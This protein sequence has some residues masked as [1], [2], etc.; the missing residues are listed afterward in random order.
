M[1]KIYN[2][3]F[4]LLAFIVLF[5]VVLGCNFSSNSSGRTNGKTE[6]TGKPSNNSEVK[7][8]SGENETTGKSGLA[9]DIIGTWEGS[10][11]GKQKITMTF[12][13]DGSMI[14]VT[15][16]DETKDS[17]D[18]TYKILD[19]KTVEVKFSDGKTI[20]LTEVEVSG[21]TLQAN[22]K[23]GEPGTFKRVS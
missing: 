1:K 23:N 14:I 22:G 16:D 8:P 11:G 4:G 7:K 17:V 19:E 15:T 3:T 10:P 12:K 20:K 5:G 21:D 13:K 9:E 2:K 6:N 18:T